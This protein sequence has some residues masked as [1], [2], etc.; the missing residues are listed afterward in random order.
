M[1]P[2]TATHLLERAIVKSSEPQRWADLGAGD[3]FF[4]RA[5]ASVIPKDS[6][7]LAVDKNASSLKSIQ[8]TF[9]Q[10][11]VETRHADFTSLTWGEH[12]DGILM[13]NALHYVGNQT[14]FL[15]KLKVKL[16]Y[17]GRLVIVEYER[18]QVNPWVPYPIP[19][20]KL[21]E[22]GAAAGFSSVEKLEETTSSYDNAMIYSACLVQ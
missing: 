4:T 12:F 20:G 5:L 16:S 18:R 3:G 13:A 21:Q 1:E 2:S 15:T 8:D 17:S 11:K 22:I 6:S 14:E 10:I 9:G 19:L 7:V